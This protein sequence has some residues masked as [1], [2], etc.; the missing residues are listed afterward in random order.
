VRRICEWSILKRQNSDSGAS[1]LLPIKQR[2]ATD[3]SVSNRKSS[4][5]H[6]KLDRPLTPLGSQEHNRS[7]SPLSRH[8]ARCTANLQRQS[9]NARPEG[10]LESTAVKMPRAGAPASPVIPGNAGYIIIPSPPPVALY[11]P[12]TAA[13][14]KAATRAVLPAVDSASNQNVVGSARVSRREN[15]DGHVPAVVRSGSVRER[16]TRAR[17]AP[18]PRESIRIL[19]YGPVTDKRLFS[20]Q[21]LLP[22]SPGRSPTPQATKV[23][24]VHR[25]LYL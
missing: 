14:R 5:T 24:P 4:S 10:I 23:R 20:S 13:S 19:L 3:R 1:F 2:T 17:T 22:I 6:L 12:V 9:R 15:D 21:C 18:Y 25:I 16:Q 7:F 11:R 8:T